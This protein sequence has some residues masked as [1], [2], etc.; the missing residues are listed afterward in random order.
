LR[1]LRDL[2]TAAFAGFE[3][4]GDDAS[5]EKPLT[6]EIDDVRAALAWSLE[7][8][9]PRLGAELLL[10]TG[11][12]WRLVGREREA[13]ER[14]EAVTN[15]LEDAEPAL[16]SR[17]RVGFAYLTFQAGRVNLAIDAVQ[18]A[19]TLARASGDPSVLARALI[20]HGRI[21]TFAQRFADA[22]AAL[23]E[24]EAIPG[25]SPLVRGMA[26]ESRAF[27]SQ[28]QGDLDAAARAFEQLAKQLSGNERMRR[29]YA[30]N[31][32]EIEHER[33]NTGRAI[34]LLRDVL[35]GARAENDPNALARYLANYAGYLV[36]AGDLPGAS[37]AVR[38]IIRDIAPNDPESPFIAGSLEHLALAIALSG[39]A[40][41][42]ARLSGYADVATQKL[43][44]MRGFTETTSHDRLHTLLQDLLEPLEAE[45]LLAEGAALT[46]QEALAEALAGD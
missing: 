34:E 39:N 35:P 11:T 8:G 28:Y 36:A 45:R 4:T 27:L 42:A 5:I 41:R 19:V 10:P 38:E 1:Y 3:N 14:T 30:L 31:L 15:A 13:R 23:S 40:P 2:F 24:A 16:L 21:A 26:L 22:E 46:P 18:E 44:F 25:G 12:T 6:D 33:G 7:G 17:L 20:A 37:E 29:A 32:G 43:G 9:D